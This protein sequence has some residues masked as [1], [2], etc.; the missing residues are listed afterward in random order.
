MKKKV[1]LSVNKRV[2]EVMQQK[3]INNHMLSSLTG[4]KYN[5]VRGYT[6]SGAPIPFPKL[7]IIAKALD[8]PTSFLLG[9]DSSLE[10]ATLQKTVAEMQKVL[11]LM[12]KIIESK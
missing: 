3:Q 1:D 2:Q 10:K 5:T 12:S 4:L 11:N 6:T 7:Q 8:V 9:E